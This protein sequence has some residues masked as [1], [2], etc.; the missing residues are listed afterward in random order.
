MYNIINTRRDD[1]AFLLKEALESQEIFASIKKNDEPHD[2]VEPTYNNEYLPGLDIIMCDR[3]YSEQYGLAAFLLA[4]P[5]KYMP[6]LPNYF[7]SQDKELHSILN[8]IWNCPALQ[9]VEHH[10]GSFWLKVHG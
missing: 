10:G 4:N 7:I 9:D 5:E 1:Y 3:F 6:I 2:A 8:P